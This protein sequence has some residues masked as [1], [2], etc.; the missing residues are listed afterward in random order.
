MRTQQVFTAFAAMILATVLG[1][2]AAAQRKPAIKSKPATAKPATA[3]PATASK[4]PTPAPAAATGQALDLKYIHAAPVLAV[5]VHPQEILALPQVRALPIEVAQAAAKEQFGID[6]TKLREVILLVSMN[7]GQQPRPALIARFSEPVD[8]A[9][10][11]KKVN[12]ALSQAGPQAPVAFIPERTT[13][14]VASREDFGEMLGAK[15]DAASPL[16]DRLRKFDA[17]DAAG[18]VVA[19]EPIRDQLLAMRAM[20]PPL[21][22]PLRE[23]AALP[24]IVDAVELHLKLG[25]KTQSALSFECRDE[26]GAAQVDRLIDQ[27]IAFA[28]GMLDQQLA[29]MQARNAS[30][31]EQASI[32]YGKRMLQETVKLIERDRQGNRLAL[33]GSGEAVLAPATTGILAGL[34]LPA[35]QASREAAR[36]SQSTNNL[37]QIGIAMHNFHDVYK[38]FPA[39]T[40]D[41]DGKPLLS[42]RVHIL[43]FV[44]AQ[45]LYQQFHLD[46]PWDSEHNK[47]LVAQMPAAFRNPNFADPEKTVYLACTG[48]HAVFAD[49]KADKG[50]A[51]RETAATT[52]GGK[53]AAWARSVWFADITDGTSNTIMVVEANPERGVIW[54]KPDDLHIDANKPLAGLGGLRPGGFYAL[55]CDGSVRFISSMINVEMLRR[56]FNPRDGM[57]IQAG[58]F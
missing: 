46:E 31:T 29:E 10:V 13:V 44:G 26:A 20:L 34:L 18:A 7:A 36:R 47:P 4:G 53:E 14:L 48:E 8:R 35:V 24:E 9:E 42:W 3:K 52:I 22:P 16:L 32:Q 55:L 38:R 45:N 33:R 40:Y 21:P 51:A 2:E 54:S 43:P 30:P 15:G 25:E 17:G 27:A 11:T 37:K 39:S 49:G 41:K 57:Q 58:G 56:L 1:S 23:A 19:I 50:H 6:L 5:V 12:Q 28:D